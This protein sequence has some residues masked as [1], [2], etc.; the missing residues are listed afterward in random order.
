MFLAELDELIATIISVAQAVITN[1]VITTS[2]AYFG[3][4]SNHQSEVF[5]KTKCGFKIL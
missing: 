3:M 1:N 4:H 2:L 5:A